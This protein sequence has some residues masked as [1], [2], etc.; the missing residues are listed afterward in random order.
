MEKLI[1][2]KKFAEIVHAAKTVLLTIHQRPD[3]DCIGSVLAMRLIL[4][5]LGKEVKIIAPHPV[6]PTL[7]F[8]DPNHVI[9]PLESATAEDKQWFQTA[10]LFFILDTSSWAQ[11]GD[12]AEHFKQSPA[13]KLILDHHVK[14]DAIEAERFV[15][16]AGEA[17]GALVVQAADALGVP[18]SAEMAVPMFTALSTDTGWF[19]FS[20]VTPQTFRTAARLIEAGVKPDDVYRKLHEQESLGRIRLVGRTLSK[21]ESFLDGQF[22]LTWIL[23]DDFDKA[24]ALSSDSEDIVNMLLQVKGTRMAVLISELKDHS[25]KVS[26]RS[27]C[28]VDCSVLAAQFGG[29]GHKKAAGAT[30]K[31]GF[32][33]TK[34][35]LIESVTN[36]VNRVQ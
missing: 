12:M 34:R 17:T 15:D 14:G 13:K 22:L 36:A 28:E 4:Q 33:E 20:S 32:E 1:D 7:A 8:L 2:W 25:F 31:T 30:L 35:M 16:D 9:I 6:P 10:D 19:R 23:S 27:R 3:G 24:G 18:I 29:G 26:F 5:H 21:T 11:L